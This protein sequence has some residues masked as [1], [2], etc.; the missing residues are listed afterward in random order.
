MID[1]QFL[2][3]S[4]EKVAEF[5]S[6]IHSSAT[7]FEYYQLS[8]LLCGI[9][10]FAGL[11]VL[12]VAAGGSDFTAEMRTR[13]SEAYA[14]DPRF[15]SLEELE[16][17]INNFSLNRNYNGNLADM[18]DTMIA[19]SQAALKQFREDYLQHTE[20]YIA[21]SATSI[22]FPDNSV[23]LAVS[24]AGLTCLASRDY[25]LLRDAVVEIVRVLKPDASLRIDKSMIVFYEQIVQ[26][27]KDLEMTA[28]VMILETDES[29]VESYP[30][31]TLIEIRKK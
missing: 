31:T 2:R 9:S 23:D 1:E 21:A 28:S 3:V 15:N 8:G 13:G 12:D 16:G 10:S 24:R 25:T 22:P 6:S 26:L 17:D 7:P 27:E 30:G 14:L 4:E 29:D 18:S 20:A 19:E 5:S 11:R